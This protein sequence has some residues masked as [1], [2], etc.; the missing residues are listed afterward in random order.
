MLRKQTTL[1]DLY[2]QIKSLLSPYWRIL[3]AS[4]IF[5]FILFVLSI[6]RRCKESNPPKEKSVE[7]LSVDYQCVFK[8]SYSK[9]FAD[10]NLLHLE[11]ARGL[12]AIPF[13]R[14][15]TEKELSSLAL[16]ESNPFYKV[17]RLTHSIPY[18]VPEAKKL[19][20]YI[21]EDFNIALQK[22][23]IPSYR[24][25]VTSLTRTEEQQQKLSKRNVNATTES[26]HSYGT[27]FDIS[28]SRFDKVHSSEADISDAIL[29]KVLASILQ[30]YQK[31]HRC[32]I[33]HEKKQ[34]CFHITTIK[35]SSSK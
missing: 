19:L 5:I 29:K 3:L 20:D 31:A 7:R 34:A 6:V 25:I 13:K 16:I 30:Q 27:T 22:R 4:F 18:L 24:I 23:G 21:G 12:Q 15:L 14:N 26:S 32:Y 1:G 11:A 10:D 8:G 28:W 2:R 17:D 33:K 35:S 9:C